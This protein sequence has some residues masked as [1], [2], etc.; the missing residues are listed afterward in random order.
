MTK[1]NIKLAIAPIGWVN[2]DL[3]ELGKGTCYKQILEEVAQAG[4]SGTELGGCFP[5]DAT[6]LNN[7][8]S[9]RNL[10]ICNSW[11]STYLSTKPYEYTEK[12]FIEFCDFLLSIGCTNIGISEQGT[13]TQ[14]K[15]IP[16]TV[17]ESA[18]NESQWESVI[19]GANKL[20]KI[21][22]DKG[23][24][25]SYHHHMCTGIQT[26]A[27]IDRFMEATN[28]QYVNLLFDTGHCSYDDI[29]PLFLLNKYIKRIKHIHLKDTRNFILAGALVNELSFLDSVI[30]GV[31]TVPSD[32]NIDF[33]PIFKVLQENDYTGWL[34]V[35]AEQ[36]PKK[37]NPLAYAKYAYDYI[38]KSLNY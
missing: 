20:G 11:F 34:V 9:L 30:E 26:I 1:S 4:F 12:L 23:M 25:M 22:Y 21:A 19:A 24:V 5:K 35:E 29:D 31:F 27:E 18:F 6:E 33:N 17:R 36:D 15:N 32:G 3:P 16:V 13:S 10:K 28:P 7:E 2:D 8:L 37:A 38:T 14:Q